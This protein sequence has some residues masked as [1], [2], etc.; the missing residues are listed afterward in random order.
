MGKIVVAMIEYGECPGGC[1]NIYKVFECHKGEYYPIDEIEKI[2]DDDT[3]DDIV[4][5]GEIGKKK[6]DR[7]IPLKKAAIHYIVSCVLKR[8]K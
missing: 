8:K 2:V 1:E 3:K 6:Y 4:I 5:I 7:S